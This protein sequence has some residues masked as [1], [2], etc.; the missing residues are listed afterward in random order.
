[1]G[2]QCPPPVNASNL[3]DI[4]NTLEKLD[5]QNIF[6]ENYKK[7]DVLITTRADLDDKWTLCNGDIAPTDS[8][9][10]EDLR[11]LWIP[12]EKW[13]DKTDSIRITNSQF[14][15]GTYLYYWSMRDGNITV[16]KR[17]FKNAI[18]NTKTVASFAPSSVTVYY[19]FA[20]NNTNLPTYTNGIYA[21]WCVVGGKD[22]YLLYTDDLDANTYKTV[23]LH[24]EANMTSPYLFYE[25]GQYVIAVTNNVTAATINMYIWYGSRIDNLTKKTITF[26][27]DG[28]SIHPSTYINYYNG[29]Y[30]LLFRDYVSNVWKTYYIKS[31]TISGLTQS[32]DNPININ[33]FVIPN[34]MYCQRSLDG[35]YLYWFTNNSYRMDFETMTE[36]TLW[37]S[38]GNCV[39]I[40]NYFVVYQGNQNSL[41]CWNLTSGIGYQL[42]SI[43]ESN[44]ILSVVGENMDM[45]II[46]YTDISTTCYPEIT[47]T[48]AYAYI[49]T[50]D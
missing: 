11:K 20:Q 8:P 47:M 46:D 37:N 3:N 5:N 4:S 29:N 1:M 36:E 22:T 23:L 45:L 15:D 12:G 31:P 39:Y 18:I 6:D 30:Y 27:S 48:G 24:S 28:T 35:R 10:Y 41:A 40:Q 25:N 14:T 32:K 34:N 13:V 50:E 7:G 44:N 9:L 19:S 42:E 33:G 17:D 26:T 2:G 43:G 38:G 16:Q 21:T 49:K